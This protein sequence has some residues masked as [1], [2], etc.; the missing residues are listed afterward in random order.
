MGTALAAH[1]TGWSRVKQS[2]TS[3][4]STEP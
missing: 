3:V 2:P 1:F 4:S